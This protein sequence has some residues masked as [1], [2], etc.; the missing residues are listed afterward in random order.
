MDE[1]KYKYSASERETI[2]RFADDSDMAIVESFNDTWKRKLLRLTET[3][4]E[5][6]KFIS[7]WERRKK[8][9]GV[10]VVMPKKYIKVRLPPVLTDEQ[11]KASG[12]RITQARIRASAENR[13]DQEENEAQN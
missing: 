4:P 5:Q 12:D 11:R 13:V 9:G 3:N 10:C 8:Y 7:D 1:N 2:I 6:V